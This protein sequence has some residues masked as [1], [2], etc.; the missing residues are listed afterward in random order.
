[1]GRI[2]GHN[3]PNDIF[4]LLDACPVNLELSGLGQQLRCSEFL[5][6]NLIALNNANSLDTFL[7]A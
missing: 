7:L 5:S 2:V 1:L 6:A 4:A 3:L